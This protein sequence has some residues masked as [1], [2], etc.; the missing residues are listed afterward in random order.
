MG[1][2]Q[3]DSLEIQIQ[4]SAK[5]A[6]DQLDK[7]VAKLEKIS[8][9]LDGINT[10]KLASLGKSF[11][12]VTSSTTTASKSVGSI[13]SRLQSMN[14]LLNKSKTSTNSLAASF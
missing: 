11:N 2:G 13:S 8:S 6:N 12:T 4:T 5:Q 10:S 1:A 3:I 9:C 7:L 14:A